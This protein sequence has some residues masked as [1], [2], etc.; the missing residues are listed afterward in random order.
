MEL[1]GSDDVARELALRLRRHYGSR[2]ANAVLFGS[3][4]R[5]NAEQ[6]SDYDVLVVLEGAVDPRRERRETRDL[7]YELCRERDVVISCHFVSEARFQ[8]ERSAFMLNVRREGVP[9]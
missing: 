4:A 2:L 1:T 5:G 6:D 9:V 8:R 7:S 3:R